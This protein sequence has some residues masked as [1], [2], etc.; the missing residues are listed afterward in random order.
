[1]ALARATAVCFIVFGVLDLILQRRLFTREMRMTQTEAK[2]EHKNM[3]GDPHI[4]HEQ[5]RLRRRLMG[6]RRASGYAMRPLP[7]CI[8]NKSRRFASS[9]AE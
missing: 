3:E 4:R 2:R 5:Q 6:G 7:S 9:R 1:M 8:G